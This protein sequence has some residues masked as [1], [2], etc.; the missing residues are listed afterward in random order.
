MSTQYYTVCWKLMNSELNP[1]RC[2]GNTKNNIKENTH[3]HTSNGF[4]SRTTWVSWHQ[5]GK[6]LW[7]LLKQEM[8]EWQWHQLDHMQ[9]ICTTLQADNHAIKGTKT[10][11]NTA[12]NTRFRWESV[13]TFLGRKRVDGGKAL[14]NRKVSSYEWNSEEV[15]NDKSDESAE[16]DHV[17][18]V[19]IGQSKRET[20]MR[21]T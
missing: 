16:H 11:T 13:N 7:I 19:G 20:E 17:T 10:E 21:L 14:W 4:F 2:V 15:M 8:M 5:E 1:S 12:Q 6:P 3:T 9:I 18:S